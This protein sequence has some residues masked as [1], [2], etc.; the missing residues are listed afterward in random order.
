MRCNAFLRRLTISIA[1]LAMLMLTLAPAISNA[2]LTEKNQSWKTICS[3]SDTLT[4]ANQRSQQGTDYPEKPHWHFAHCQYCFS[5]AGTFILP[6]SAIVFP[7]RLPESFHYPPAFYQSS[8]PLF[9]WFTP[10]PRAPPRM[11]AA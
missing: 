1:I 3:T 10:Q 6:V 9:I 7:L 11:H 4:T 8:S 5:H 2:I